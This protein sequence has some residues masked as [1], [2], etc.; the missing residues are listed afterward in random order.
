[1]LI[2]RGPVSSLLLSLL[3]VSVLMW[4]IETR[5]GPQRRVWSLAQ[6]VPWFGTLGLR[7][8]AAVGR[9]AAAAAEVR[10][11]ALA[12]SA[13][14]VRA[15]SE[16]AW[17]GRALAVV[18]EHRDVQAR[19]E[20]AAR[21]RYAAG[22]GAYADVLRAQVELARLEDRLVSLR[23]RRRPLA[24]A[25]NAALGRDP[26][27]PLPAPDALSEPQPLPGED[28]LQALLRERNPALAAVRARE[29]SLASAEGLARK[30]GW[31]DLTLGLDYIE[32]GTNGSG[33]PGEG[34]DPVIARLSLSLPLWR[35]SVA[36]ARREA[37]AR[38]RAQVSAVTDLGRD[39][40]SRLA[41][42][43]FRRRDAERRLALHDRTLLPRSREI[44]TVLEASY[45]AGGAGYLDLVD[46]Q[47]TLL[48][49]ELERARAAA[50]LA[51]L[52]AELQELLGGRIPA[53]E[54]IAGEEETP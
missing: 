44:L 52:D 31:P 23:D 40:A 46:A 21:A 14:V 25:L 38:H 42:A 39:L 18:E 17:V 54:S 13:R 47:R 27:A 30:G 2:V 45:A 34:S 19:A 33:M 9:T 26:D 32:T 24:A 16:L 10:A 1:M 35:G 43:L 3:V 7:R 36:A 8:A 41:D 20:Q 11:E 5:L 49:F 15:W 37:A 29:S 6:T 12:V 53:A 48:A 51:A 50:D 28:R 4:F 22:E